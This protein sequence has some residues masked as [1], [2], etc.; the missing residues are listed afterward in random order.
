MQNILL[1]LNYHLGSS[2]TEPC[3]PVTAANHSCRYIL[4]QSSISSLQ[5]DGKK[6]KKKRKKLALRAFCHFNTETHRELTKAL[7][8]N[9]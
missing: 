2:L 6:R 3:D 5:D 8:S 9:K 1:H 4:V 7:M